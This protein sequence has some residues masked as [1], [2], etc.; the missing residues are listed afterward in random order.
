VKKRT[1]TAAIYAFSLC[2]GLILS[3]CGGGNRP[4]RPVRFSSM[5]SRLPRRPAFLTLPSGMDRIGSAD[6]R[7]IFVLDWEGYRSYTFDLSA[8]GR[9]ALE[10]AEAT[11]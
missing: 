11:K 4:N 8:D 10:E 2:D 6:G 9:T 7:Y 5:A 3:G 1:L